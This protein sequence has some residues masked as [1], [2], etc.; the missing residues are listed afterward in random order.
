VTP[1]RVLVV[2]ANVALAGFVI[3]RITGRYTGPWEEPFQPTANAFVAAAL[4]QDSVALARLA[5]SSS[6]V[7]TALATAARHPERLAHVGRL[8]VWTAKRHGDTTRVVYGVDPCPLMFTFVG[9]GRGTR[10]AE[11]AVLCGERR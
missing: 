4:R 7:D 6:T 9:N 1:T 10:I 11:F 8:R 5:V 2:V 3:W